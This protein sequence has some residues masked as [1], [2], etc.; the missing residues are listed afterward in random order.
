LVPSYRISSSEHMRSPRVQLGHTPPPF[1]VLVQVLQEPH[2]RAQPCH[3]WEQHL[4][5][6]RIREPPNVKISSGILV[7]PWHPVA[8]FCN[9]STCHIPHFRDDM[10]LQCLPCGSQTWLAGKSIIYGLQL[11]FPLK[12]P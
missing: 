7:L 2:L 3:H 10:I 4:V 6:T 1:S 5:W 8:S 11:I 12:A 9:W